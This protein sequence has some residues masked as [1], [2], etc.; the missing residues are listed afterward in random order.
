MLQAY[1]RENLTTVEALELFQHEI[2]EK[3]D[4]HILETYLVGKETTPT[5]ADIESPSKRQLK[6]FARAYREGS[7]DNP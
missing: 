1:V 6:E 5:D 4:A 7:G 3:V 2:L